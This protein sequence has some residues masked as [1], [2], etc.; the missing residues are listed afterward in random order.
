[1]S[2]LKWQSF[3]GSIEEIVEKFKPFDMHVSMDLIKRAARSLVLAKSDESRAI[4]QNILKQFE[5]Q[6]ALLKLKTD[7]LF[8]EVP[9]KESQVGPYCLGNF[10]QGDNEYHKCRLTSAD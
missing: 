10:L 6:T 9:T 2:K 4:F 3:D 7:K 8:I 5:S 1:M